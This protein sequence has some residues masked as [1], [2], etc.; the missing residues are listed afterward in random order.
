MTSSA[1]GEGKPRVGRCIAHLASWPRCSGDMTTLFGTSTRPGPSIVPTGAD[2][3]ITHTDLD[4]AIARLR[5]G[6]E[7]DRRAAL[8]LLEA[9]R[10]TS[11][12]P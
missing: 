6:T 10:A 9:V 4:E 3:W 1:P 8:E 12:R 2:I 11:Q 5:R 7:D